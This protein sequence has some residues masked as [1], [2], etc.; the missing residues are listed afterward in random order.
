VLAVEAVL[1]VLP[2]LAVLVVEAV[3]LLEAVSSFLPQP[4]TRAVEPTVR[5]RAG[6]PALFRCFKS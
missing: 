1:L 6:F 3:D 5:V 2:V 4:V